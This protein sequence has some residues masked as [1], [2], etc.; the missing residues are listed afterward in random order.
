MN[1]VESEI[2][3]SVGLLLA[4]VACLELGFRAGK[5]NLEASQSAHEGIGAIEAAVFA[6]LGLLLAFSYAGATERFGV[7][8]Q[9]DRG[10][11]QPERGSLSP[12]GLTPCD[13]ATGSPALIPGLSRCAR[14][15]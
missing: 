14:T 12:A 2:A 5:R 9:P 7:S 15:P 13:R 3:L 8:A 11:G 10:R 1:Q 6:L 4:I